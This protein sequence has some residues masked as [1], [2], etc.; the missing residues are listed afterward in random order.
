MRMCTLR[1]LSL[2][3]RSAT[4]WVWL[5]DLPHR[6]AVGHTAVL[7]LRLYAGG[8]LSQPVGRARPTPTGR[9]TG[10]ITW[11][12]GATC[13]VVVRILAEYTVGWSTVV[14]ATIAAVSGAALYGIAQCAVARFTGIV[15]GF[16]CGLSGFVVTAVV[17]LM[18]Y[19]IASGLFLIFVVPAAAVVAY[20]IGQRSCAPAVLTRISGETHGSRPGEGHGHPIGAAVTIVVAAV[21]GAVWALPWSSMIW[22][23]SVRDILAYGVLSVAV[24]SVW[25]TAHAVGYVG[26]NLMTTAVRAIVVVELLSVAAAS[27]A[28]VSFVLVRQLAGA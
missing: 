1:T 13:G 11:L 4:R 28:M 7:S 3:S 20:M 27:I 16:L 22:S 18:Y 19:P 17:G 9:A 5:W 26:G 23:V 12:I 15:T 6:S 21:T 2:I 14:I 25:V 24:P 10:L 8:M